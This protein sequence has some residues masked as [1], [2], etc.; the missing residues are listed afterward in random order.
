ML[1]Q[2]TS[3]SYV[4]ATGET[5]TVQDFVD[6]AAETL[7]LSLDWVGD[8]SDKVG[9]DRKTGRPVVTVDPQ[10]FRPA[11]VNI[12]QGC[13]DKASQELAWTPKVTFRQLVERMAQADFDRI[14]SG[15]L[16]F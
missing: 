2:P 11:E 4:L 12:L 16:R 13:A 3:G 5:H 9:R 15:K 14:R 6:V 8:G 7:G 10:F 1:Q